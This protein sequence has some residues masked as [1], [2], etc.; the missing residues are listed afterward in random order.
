MIA[1]S[2]SVS[3]YEPYLVYVCG[4]CSPGVLNP[5]S[6]YHSSC[7]SSAGFPELQVYGPNG[8][9]QFLIEYYR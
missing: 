6:A 5:P 2:V 8:E 1:A 3:T 4:P 9:L 7:S